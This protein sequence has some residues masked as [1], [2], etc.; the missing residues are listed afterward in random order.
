MKKSQISDMS[1]Q[2]QKKIEQVDKNLTM[3]VY[4]LFPY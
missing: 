3:K 2:N 1:K 4:P